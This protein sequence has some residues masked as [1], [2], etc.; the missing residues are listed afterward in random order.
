MKKNGSLTPNPSLKH[1]EILVGDWTMELSN[2]SFLP[3]SSDTV[4]GHVSFEWLEGGAFLVMYM[5]DKPPGTPDATWLM[6][7]DE[8]TPNYLVLYYDTRRVSR[9]YEMS[10]SKGMWNMWRNSPDF[11]QRFEGKFSEDGNTIT[12]H[13]EKSSSGSTWEHDFDVTY[14]RVR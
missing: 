8:S 13:W 11:S 7:R 10:F 14:T 6:S 2:A 5:G 3:S 9:I 1:L 12:A 4:T